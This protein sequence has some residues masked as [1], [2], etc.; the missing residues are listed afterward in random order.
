[1]NLKVLNHWIGFPGGSVVVQPA[2][3]E[4]PEMQV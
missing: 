2:T 4:M 3:Q 1:M